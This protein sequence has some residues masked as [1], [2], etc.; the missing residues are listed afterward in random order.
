MA[1]RFL[2]PL[3][4][5]NYKRRQVQY[6]RNNAYCWHLY[7]DSTHQTPNKMVCNLCL[8][9]RNKHPNISTK[10][11][12][13]VNFANFVRHLL[14]GSRNLAQINIYIDDSKRPNRFCLFESSTLNN[15]QL[16]AK[17]QILSPKVIK[18]NHQHN[19]KNT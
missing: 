17:R 14:S 6:P 9:V 15:T 19:Y 12:L 1:R 16:L 4:T 10:D 13:K 8:N 2:T 5:L 3:H 11:W 7:K 18:L